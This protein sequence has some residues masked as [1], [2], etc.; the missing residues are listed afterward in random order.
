MFLAFPAA[1]WETDLRRYSRR[2]NA[3]LI[4]TVSPDVPLYI[5]WK[6]YKYSFLSFPILIFS[7]S[8]DSERIKIDNLILSISSNTGCILLRAF[9]VIF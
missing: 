5:F 9:A 4:V 7:I 3:I 1:H 8:S 6:L 2:M